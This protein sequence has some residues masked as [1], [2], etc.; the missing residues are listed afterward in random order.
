MN[1]HVFNWN[2][3][4]I[5]QNRISVI[6]ML[7]EKTKGRN[8]RYLEIGC[9]QNVVFNSIDVEYKVGV[10][11]ASGGTIRTTSDEFFKSNQQQFDVIFI[12]GLHHYDQVHRDAVNS[13]NCLAP[14]GWIVFHDLLPGNDN[15]QKVPRI[16]AE[17]TGDC[18]KLA[19][20]LTKSKGLDFHIV[21]V[22][23]GVGILRKISED[24]EV[25]DMSETLNGA[26][27]DLFVE[28]VLG[29]M[30]PIIEYEEAKEY[31]AS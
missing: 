18:W 16:Q 31:V 13:L 5:P 29:G 27:F 11:P 21:K 10:D 25:A 24:W 7:V 4:S 23:Q 26:Q 8:T 14:G 9:D 6:Q 30:L 20:E 2:W 19:I 17:W 28:T 22:D 1:G 3:H 12:D 15:M